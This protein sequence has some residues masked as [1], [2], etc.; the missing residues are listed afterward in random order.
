[1]KPQ[2]DLKFTTGTAARLAD[3]G[4]YQHISWVRLPFGGNHGVPATAEK[5]F[6]QTLGFARGNYGG[7][8]GRTT[9]A[10]AVA[11]HSNSIDTE[12]SCNRQLQVKTPRDADIQSGGP[13]GTRTFELEGPGTERESWDRRSSN[14]GPK[15][16]TIDSEYH[17]LKK[18]RSRETAPLEAQSD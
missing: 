7:N 4:D 13:L 17:S 10:A 18:D 6:L 16:V 14:Q 5:V 11:M 8:E 9:L 2:H 1:M 3:A 15:E 12:G